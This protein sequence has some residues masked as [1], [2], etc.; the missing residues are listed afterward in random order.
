MAVLGAAR[1]GDTVAGGSIYA[2]RGK[3]VYVN[4]IPVAT[5]NSMV[6]PHPKDHPSV[7]IVSASKT[8]YTS[9]GLFGIARETDVAACGHSISTASST[10]KV[11]N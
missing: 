1:E 4:G 6:T 3:N 5:E 8:V 10:V 2:T 7:P 9:N 11:G